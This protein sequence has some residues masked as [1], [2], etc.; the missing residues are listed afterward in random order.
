MSGKIDA[1]NIDVEFPASM[2]E[3]SVDA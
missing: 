2:Q 1:E 3:E